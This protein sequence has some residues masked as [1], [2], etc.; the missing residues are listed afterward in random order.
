MRARRIDSIIVAAIAFAV[1]ACASPSEKPSESVAERTAAVVGG[2]LD[3]ADPAVAAILPRRIDCASPPPTPI[4][5]GTLIAPRVVLT[6]A[7]CIRGTTDLEVYFGANAVDASGQFDVVVASAVH[8]KFDPSSNAYD[9][10]LLR[11]GDDPGVKPVPMGALAPSDVGIAARVVGFGTDGTTGSTPGTK[12]QGLTKISSIDV[13]SFR[14]APNPAMSCVGD[15]GGPVLVATGDAGD[16]T[17]VG[18]TVA[19][20]VACKTYALDVRVDAVRDFVD[21][22][23][24]ATATAPSGMPSGSFGLPAICTG[25]CGSSAEC[26]AALECDSTD[27][28][29]CVLSGL[30]PMG[31]AEECSAASPCAMGARCV[32]IWPSGAGACRCATPCAGAPIP[33]APSTSASTDT[34]SSGGC[35]T[36]HSRE[37]RG[38]LV[39][40]G[41][42][43]VAMARS[44]RRR[45]R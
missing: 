36:T 32:R 7:H 21:P 41:A 30:A 37:D 18:V 29:R 2:A 33:P 14:A 28:G 39:A 12:R 8:P 3:S 25:Q 1:G 43:V 5:S 44:R 26:P 19:G 6:A 38:A 10:A 13:A 17:L 45:S 27:A 23:V 22:F 24:A 31:F 11:L 9:V 42:L 35:S 40:S 15:S 16:E 4:C 20:D 34:G